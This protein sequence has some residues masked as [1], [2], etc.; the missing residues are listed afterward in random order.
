MRGM[1]DREGERMRDRGEGG[2]REDGEEGGKR[3]DER[4]GETLYCA[5]LLLTFS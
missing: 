1:E 2:G 4:D 3:E 5:V